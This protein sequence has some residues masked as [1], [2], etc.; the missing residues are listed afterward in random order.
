MFEKSIDYLD[1]S[2][3]LY[4]KVQGCFLVPIDCIDI[5][6]GVERRLK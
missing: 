6:S 5:S 4:A 1:A 2:C 3:S